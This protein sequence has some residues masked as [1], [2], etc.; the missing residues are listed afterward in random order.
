MENILHCSSNND[1]KSQEMSENSIKPLESLDSSAQTVSKPTNPDP[2]KTLNPESSNRE[3]ETDSRPCQPSLKSRDIGDPERPVVEAEPSNPVQG[4]AIDT[5]HK[6]RVLVHPICV[7]QGDAILLEVHHEGGKYIRKSIGSYMHVSQHFEGTQVDTKLLSGKR[8]THLIDG[9]RG[10]KTQ[11]KQFYKHLKET[12]RAEGCMEKAAGM[13]TAGTLE[14]RR[15]DRVVSDSIIITHPDKDH[16]GGINR[17]LQDFTIVCPITTTIATCVYTEHTNPG[18]KRHRKGEIFRTCATDLVQHRFPVP[19][20][21]KQG[22]RHTYIKSLPIRS[23]AEITKNPGFTGDLNQSSIITMVNLPGTKYDYD[24]VLTGD[25]H[26]NIIQRAL[27]LEGKSVGVFQVPHHGSRGNYSTTPSTIA[28]CTRFYS[29]FRANVYLICHG[30]YKNFKHPHKEVITGILTAAVEKRHRCK[31][32]VTATWFDGCKI[33]LTE[34]KDIRNWR[35]CV[36]I[37]HFKEDTPYVTLDLTVEQMHEGLQLYDEKVS[38][39]PTK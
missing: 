39:I 20:D 36:E 13:G 3:A 23:T 30:D 24:A 26:G 7:G 35:D 19:Q 37:Y 32:V 10:Q 17:L 31:I 4:S 8:E 2:K 21:D 22:R 14:D 18:V 27:D 38:T 15:C 28:Q 33:V 34:Y 6:A 16:C 5:K 1:D 29:S 9:G 12:L 25:S 11:N